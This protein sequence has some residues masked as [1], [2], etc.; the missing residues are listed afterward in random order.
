MRALERPISTD[1]ALLG[2][3]QRAAFGYFLSALNPANGLIGGTP[4]TEGTYRVTVMV[5]NAFD[6]A[7][8][9]FMWT[10]GRLTSKSPVLGISIPTAGQ[11]FTTSEPFVL[12]GGSADD[13]Q[14]VTAVYWTN[15]RGGSDKAT[16]TA[17]WVA[18]V[19]LR[20]GRNEITITAVDANANQSR[21]RLSV[22][23]KV[24]VPRN[25]PSPL[26]RPSN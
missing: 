11:K 23:H 7:S 18:A 4:N 5:T 9:T 1:D 6:T 14:G 19:P 22:Y 25:P 15:D 8:E 24:G 21:V 16:G 10:V 20:P 2:S 12:I 3:L 17:Q 13:D 26:G